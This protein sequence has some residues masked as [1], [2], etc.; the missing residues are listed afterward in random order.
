MGTFAC[1]QN[2]YSY[3]PSIQDYYCIRFA[4]ITAVHIHVHA[5][6][7]GLQASTCIKYCTC[8]CTGSWVKLVILEPHPPIMDSADTL[9]N[10]TASC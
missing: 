9:P 5:Q 4:C 10:H 2:T 8:V 6:A 1:I 3:V 7:C